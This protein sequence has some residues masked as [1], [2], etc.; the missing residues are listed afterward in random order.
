MNSIS[1]EGDI[2][3]PLLQTNQQEEETSNTFNNSTFENQKQQEIITH[4]Q[5]EENATQQITDS[6]QPNNQKPIEYND[7][8]ISLTWNNTYHISVFISIM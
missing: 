8:W 2:N 5:Q 1:N 6:S 4:Q 7:Y 3:Q